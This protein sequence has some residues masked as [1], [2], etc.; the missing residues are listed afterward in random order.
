MK[1]EKPMT[2]NILVHIKNNMM[3]SLWNSKFADVFCEPIDDEVH[4]FCC[5]ITHWF[6]QFVKRLWVAAYYLWSYFVDLSCNVIS[7]GLM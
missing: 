3:K 5:T 4:Q 7:G 1:T 2:T 6:A